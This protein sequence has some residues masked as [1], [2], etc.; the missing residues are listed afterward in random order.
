[1]KAITNVIQYLAFVLCV[2][3]VI[4]PNLSRAIIGIGL[5]AL[6]AMDSRED[7]VRNSDGG[8]K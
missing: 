8:R 5:I 4:S 2:W 7:K 6:T 1:M 3:T